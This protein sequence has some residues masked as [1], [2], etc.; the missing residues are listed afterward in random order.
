[1]RFDGEGASVGSSLNQEKAQPITN[2]GSN[3]SRTASGAAVTAHGE[4]FFKK[5]NLG[6]RKTDVAKPA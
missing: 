5:E 3:V 6:R 2:R 1:M 4:S